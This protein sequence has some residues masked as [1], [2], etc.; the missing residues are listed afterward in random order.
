M[1]AASAVQVHPYET[2]APAGICFTLTS[3]ER[4]R[5]T[6]RSADTGKRCDARRRVDAV[7]GD[8]DPD[9]IQPRLRHHERSSGVRQVPQGRLEAGSPGLLVPALERLKLKRNRRMAGLVGCGEV[10]PDAHHFDGPCVLGL[11]CRGAHML[12]VVAG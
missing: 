3:C 7:R 12:P 8:A 4:S 1:V 2:L 9:Q 6:G 5:I 10:R 11:G